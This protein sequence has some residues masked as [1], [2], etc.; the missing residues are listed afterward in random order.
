MYGRK[1][2]IRNIFNDWFRICKMSFAIIQ[3]FL[4]SAVY[5]QNELHLLSIH[6]K[7]YKINGSVKH[8][9]SICNF[10]TIDFVSTNLLIGD[11]I[12][13]LIRIQI[14]VHC[15]YILLSCIQSVEVSCLK[16]KQINLTNIKAAHS[17]I[18]L[19]QTYLCEIGCHCTG[20]LKQDAMDQLIVIQ[21]LVWHKHIL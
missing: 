14:F 4:M 9:H 8:N 11:G 15:E 21:I 20:F 3:H 13:Q 18:E 19:C 17:F 7:E 16:I 2:I 5:C 1:M 6:T 10:Y 12:T